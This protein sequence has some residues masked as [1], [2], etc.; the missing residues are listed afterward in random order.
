MIIFEKTL[1]QLGQRPAIFLDRDGTLNEDPGYLSDP[2]QLKLLPDVGVSLK[3]LEQAGFLLVVVSNQSGVA[4]GLITR[5]NLILIHQKMD[6]LLKPA[7]VRIFDYRLCLHHPDEQCLCRK[8]H[9]QMLLD[10]AAEYNLTLR[11]S[12]MIGDRLT[13]VQAGQRAGCGKT[14]LL[15]WVHLGSASP[16]QNFDA[17]PQD[18]YVASSLAQAVDWILSSHA[19]PS[20]PPPAATATS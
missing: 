9:P 3:R 13:D 15:R 17:I 2:R 6:E 10:A 5:K 16:E 4:R 12:V 19:N 7:G 8:P 1:T 20:S 14:V 18:T 11:Q